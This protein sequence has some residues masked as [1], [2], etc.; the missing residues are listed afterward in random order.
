[1]AKVG[2]GVLYTHAN[3]TE[4]R[5]IT[6]EYRLET[7]KKYYFNHYQ[8]FDEA[9]ERKLARN[10][11]CLI[12]DCHSYSAQHMTTT[13]AKPEIC[14][15]TDPYHTPDNMAQFALAY[16]KEAGFTT[17]INTPFAGTIVPQKFYHKD[18]RVCSIML[19]IDRG[20][21]LEDSEHKPYPQRG[22]NFKHVAGFIEN[23]VY[24]LEKFCKDN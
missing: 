16:A 15:G 18:P 21:Y 13:Q 7:L 24:E 12:I 6:P 22:K 20:L 23:L 2:Q 9:I 17:G 10:K 11:K 4:I 8:A 14:I 1:M 3:G 5:K 19:E